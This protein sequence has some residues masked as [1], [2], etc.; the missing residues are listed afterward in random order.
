MLLVGLHR[1]SSPTQTHRR[2]I[3]HGAT[4]HASGAGESRGRS[5]KHRHITLTLR[6]AV[7][8]SSRGRWFMGSARSEAPLPNCG[9]YLTAPPTT[10]CGAADMAGGAPTSRVP[11]GSAALQWSHHCQRAPFTCET[12]GDGP[13]RMT[14]LRHAWSLQSS[15]SALN[16]PQVLSA[17]P[18]FHVRTLQEGQLGPA[19]PLA[20]RCKLLWSWSAPAA[21]SYHAE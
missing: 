16:M 17:A 1:Q 2:T 14:D 9:T 19:L 6:S 15:P 21:C 5:A 20:H 11:R 12:C 18:S 7:S 8:S 3:R 13:S 10:C 4:Q